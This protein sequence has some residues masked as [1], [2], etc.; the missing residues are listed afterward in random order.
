LQNNVFFLNETEITKVSVSFI[1]LSNDRNTY[2][3]KVI[4]SNMRL[5]IFFSFLFFVQLGCAQQKTVRYT[6]LHKA[7]EQYL[8]ETIKDRRFKH[9]DITSIIHSLPQKFKVKEL[10]QS[11]EGRSIYSVSIGSGPIKVLL[12]SQMHGDEPTATMA[13]MDIFNFFKESDE[14]DS[15]KERILEQATLVFV[16][17]LNPDGAERFER[18]NALGIDLNRD[19]VR[20][21]TPEAKILKEIRDQLDADWGF[22]LHDQSRYYSAGSN[23][24]TASISFLAPAFNYDKDI[25]T[26]RGDAMKLIVGM[27]RI[28]QE[29]IPGNVAKYN[30]TFEP[31]AFGD[32]IQKWGTRTILIESGGLENDLEKQYLRK[33][34]FVILLSS[35]DAI[36]KGWYKNESIKDYKKIPFNRSSRFMDLLVREVQ[37]ERN[38]DWYTVDLGFRNDEIDTEG[39]TNFYPQAGISDIGDLSVYYAYEDINLNGAK[40]YEGEVYQKTFDHWNELARINPIELIKSGISSIRVRNGISA[41]KAS[42][43][44]LQIISG[45]KK[46]NNQVRLGGNPALIIKKSGVV[47]HVL[48]N[49]KLFSLKK[50]SQKIQELWNAQFH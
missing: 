10:G 45:E 44:P 43:L 9:R 38:G 39:A 23:P 27:N 40:A 31:R 47:S 26:V 16:P 25:N 12:W 7:H 6:D 50:D 15:F 29:Y 8:E 49:G 42:K 13:I 11:I 19:A 17:M 30:D 18:R 41:S 36:A 21:Q 2:I 28:L 3:A 1:P 48:V 22:N 24:N 32:N 4:Q 35:F 14:Y 20:L 34:H 46:V 37:I 5:S 33:L